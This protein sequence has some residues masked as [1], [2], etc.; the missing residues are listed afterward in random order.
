MTEKYWQQD[1]QTP[2]I[3][4]CGGPFVS[5]RLDLE[6]SSAKR[7]EMTSHKV[8]QTC[9]EL[10]SKMLHAPFERKLSY[11]GARR[12]QS[13]WWNVHAEQTDAAVPVYPGDR[14]RF[15]LIRKMLFG[16]ELF[17]VHLRQRHK[18]GIQRAA[19]LIVRGCRAAASSTGNRISYIIILHLSISSSA[20]AWY[21]EVQGS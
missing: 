10:P 4:A 21:A 14:G 18:L 1:G 3:T 8:S 2:G 5:G 20:L 13:P 16:H 7:L 12:C 11:S 19:L 9:S 6:R 17:R 15:N